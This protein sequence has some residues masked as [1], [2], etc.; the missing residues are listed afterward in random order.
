MSQPTVTL[1]GTLQNV[2]GAAEAG[3]LLL[4]LQGFGPQVPRIAGTSLVA[5]TNATAIPVGT[6]GTFSAVVYPNDA[7]NPPGTYYTL[8]V[9]DSNGSVIQVQAYRFLAP[10]TAF[11]LTSFPPFDPTGSIVASIPAPQLVSV[12]WSPAPQFDGTAGLAFAF[13]LQGPVA[14]SFLNNPVPGNLYTFLLTQAAQ[15]QTFVWPSTF[16][17]G[18]PISPVP[19]SLT[20]Q[21]FVCL[22]DQT[23]AAIAPAMYYAPAP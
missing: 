6:D 16:D 22:A 8:T 18:S 19:L 10:Q 1:T 23:M 7:I 17:G 13:A 5:R 4:R 20:V 12:P 21:T 9:M 14:S 11:D 2:S 3:S 15:A